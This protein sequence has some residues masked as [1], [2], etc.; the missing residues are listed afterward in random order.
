MTKIEI[1]TND[2]SPLGCSSKTVWGDAWRLGVG[3][4]ELALLT[5]CEQWIIEG[6]EVILY[7]NPREAGASS[8]EQRPISKFNPNDERDILITFRSPNPRSLAAKGL[9]VWWS[10][11]QF[12]VGDFRQFAPYMNKIVLIS[13]YHQKYFEKHSLM[14]NHDA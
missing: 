6:H 9:K 3:G 1:L 2:G 8:F 7:N 10:C 13:P 11:D 12:T 4:A 5:M 14:K